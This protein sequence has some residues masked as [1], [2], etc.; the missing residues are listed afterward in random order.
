MCIR[1]RS[2][3]SSQASAHFGSGEIT[4]SGEGRYAVRCEDGQLDIKPA[5][6]GEPDGAV[7]VEPNGGS[8]TVACPPTE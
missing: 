5:E 3:G 8:V 2:G 6:D 4:L 7:I 1:G